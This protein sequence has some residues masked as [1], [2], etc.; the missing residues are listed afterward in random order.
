[1]STTL[2]HPPRFKTD[3]APHTLKT[4][5]E[6]FDAVARGEKTFEIRL[7]DR[8]FMVGD[9]LLLR[10]TLYTG[11]QMK[12]GA[13][14]IYTGETIRRRVGYILRGP[15]YGLADGWVIMAFEPERPGKEEL[16]G[17]D[18][19]LGSPDE[20]PK[21]KSLY[22]KP[23][24]Y[25]GHL[26]DVYDILDR[27]FAPIPHVIGHAIKKLLVLGKRSGGKSPEH[28]ANDAIWSINRWKEMQPK[29]GS[30]AKYEP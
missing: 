1:M 17:L 11:A 26:I 10:R 25:C 8:G 5:P 2:S 29:E 21:P 18:R 4:D 7:D 19:L 16:E 28:D 3:P 14:L 30:H 22:H 20:P 6:V 13:Q 27:M 24:P 9:T 23:C 15:A 12:E